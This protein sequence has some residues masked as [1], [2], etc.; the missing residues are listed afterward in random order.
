ML[1]VGLDSRAPSEFGES[2]HSQVF[3]TA[4]YGLAHF[5]VDLGLY[6]LVLPKFIFA[7][8]TDAQPTHLAQSPDCTAANG[9]QDLFL[10]LSPTCSFGA[11]TAGSV[12]W[13]DQHYFLRSIMVTIWS[14][15]AC[16]TPQ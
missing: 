2:G 10:S 3:V 8:G 1:G 16:S 5:K 4:K 14:G 13:A 7:D 9:L 15:L 12:R 6:T 11:V